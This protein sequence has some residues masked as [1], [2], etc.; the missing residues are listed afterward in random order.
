VRNPLSSSADSAA[1]INRVGTPIFRYQFDLVPVDAP[2]CRRGDLDRILRRSAFVNLFRGIR[3]HSVP[4]KSSIL[5][6]ADADRPSVT[7]RSNS[8][9]LVSSLPR[10]ATAQE[11]DHASAR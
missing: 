11:L 4:S 7:A 8:A 6:S 5:P 3:S 1:G 10:T 9:M 2:P